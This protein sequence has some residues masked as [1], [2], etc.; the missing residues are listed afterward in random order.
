MMSTTSFG[1]AMRIESSGT[2]DCPPAITAASL[3]S[4]ASAACASAIVSARR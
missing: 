3:P 2:S 1:R 4:A